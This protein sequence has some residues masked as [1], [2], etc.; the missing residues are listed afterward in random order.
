MLCQ[1]E[2]LGSNGGVAAAIS[3]LVWEAITIV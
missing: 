1:I 3:A 2:E